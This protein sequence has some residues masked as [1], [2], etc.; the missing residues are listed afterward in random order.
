M[1]KGSAKQSNPSDFGWRDVEA[2]P[3]GY[4]LQVCQGSAA[5]EQFLV[6]DTIDE[7]LTLIERFP[8]LLL[9][10]L[11]ASL[12]HLSQSQPTEAGQ[13]EMQARADFLRQVQQM[14]A[15][16]RATELAGAWA[17]LA[18]DLTEESQGVKLLNLQVAVLLL[19]ES[20]QQFP[21]GEAAF[22]R[23]QM[24]EALARQELGERGLMQE[25][26]W[27]LAL[28]LYAAARKGIGRQSPDYAACLVNEANL[29]LSIAEQYGTAQELQQAIGLYRQA[30]PRFKHSPEYRRI[31][32]LGEGNAYTTLA[33]IGVSPTANLKKAIDRFVAARN[34]AMPTDIT[35]AR[36]LINEGVARI[37]LAERGAAARENY[38]QAVALL[39][40][41]R[42][43]LKDCDADH[44]RARINEGNARCG[45]AEQGSDAE[46]N[47]RQAVELYLS[48]QQEIQADHPDYALCL[49]N[50]GAARTQL[51]E[52][53]SESQANWERA[54]T[55]YETARE[56]FPKRSLNA[57]RCRMNEGAARRNLADLGIHPAANLAQAVTLYRAARQ[58]FQPGSVSHARSLMNEATTRLSMAEWGIDPHRN[59]RQA[60]T[61]YQS[62]AAALPRT[63]LSWA[64]CQLSECNARTLLAEAGVQPDLN[65]R[66][67]VQLARAARK[68]LASDRL[69]VASC[70]VNE[71]RAL[72]AL[73]EGSGQRTPLHRARRLLQQS[74]ATLTQAGVQ[75]EALIANQLLGTVATALGQWEEAHDAFTTA[76][77]QAERLR[78]ETQPHQR[79]RVQA[80]NLG[81][82]QAAIE[83][84]LRTESYGV[85][86][87]DIERLRSRALSDLLSERDRPPRKVSAEKWS[88][89]Q[90]LMARL[91]EV[92]AALQP[93]LVSSPNNLSDE[94][95]STGQQRTA[96]LKERNQME[97]RLDLLEAEIRT[98]DP[99]YR[100]AAAGLELEAMQETA[101][102]LQRTLVSFH[103][104]ELGT[105][106]F[107]LGPERRPLCLRS[108][109]FTVQRLR[110][111]VFGAKE[112]AGW[113]GEYQR[114]VEAFQTGQLAQ[115]QQRWQD[116]MIA[117][118]QTL[119]R[120]LIGPL[121][122]E[123]R[124]RGES[125]VVFIA[126]GLLGVLPLHAAAWEDADGALRYLVEEVEVSYAPSI[127]ILRRCLDRRRPRVDAALV[128]SVSGNQPSRGGYAGW[129]ANRIASL[130]RTRLDVANVR[131]FGEPEY[132]TRGLCETVAEPKV[133]LET[134]PQQTLCHLTC[135]G[136]WDAEEYLDSGLQLVGEQPLTL[137]QLLREARL[138]R[139][140]FVAL[141][142][143]ESSLGLQRDLSVEEY[144]GLPIGFLA[145]GA[146]SVV[147]SLWAVPE[148]PSSFLMV[149]LYHHLLDG[150][151]LSEALQQAQQWI[152]RA[153]LEEKRAFLRAVNHLNPPVSERSQ[154]ALENALTAS[155]NRFSHPA[156]WAAFQA[157]GAAAN[158]IFPRRPR[159]RETNR[160]IS[161]R[162]L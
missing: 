44:Q 128:A 75:H 133:L 30:R 33:E 126:G 156:A 118:L 61:L 99:D 150:V 95:K 85:A 64:R 137:R 112:K 154:Q 41:A 141:S 140:H 71:A 130:L 138:S 25:L 38:Q 45:L 84:S 66:A 129:E 115:V 36:S 96:L 19:R 28:E 77:A 27:A 29:R 90:H 50:E 152:I 2:V 37:A 102:R 42:S 114:Y 105:A 131:W 21:A 63:S 157:I 122:E 52:L 160:P 123:L 132:V 79:Q 127:A 82:Y 70:Q 93:P 14:F 161:R 35:D 58:S 18:F 15:E 116:Q 5:I 158:V 65:L 155:E 34:G 87:S 51:A 142:A 81:I 119:Y 59:L 26:N 11:P 20:R 6:V 60:V 103:V 101:E 48:V 13:Q 4:W 144:L 120:E 107:L 94:D 9:A 109:E 72:Y 134:L 92:D 111:L 145:A 40:S 124:Q 146:R 147:G 57:G 125:R 135:H 143:C 83:I 110:E 62:A 98:K 100:F 78:Y 113:V 54:A 49:M 139:T 162:K 159:N 117:T 56:L 22:A 69:N 7:L 86:L 17:S 53:G 8:I 3:L 91:A 108:R 136:K 151:S 74:A 106:L 67:A 31:C 148:F 1:G 32:F 149:R 55:L 153:P 121:H 89:W 104:G 47:L 97:A 16:Q 76:I 39:V 23:C 88:E 12:E 73:A 80:R 68:S 10:T 46:E 43:V 24:Q